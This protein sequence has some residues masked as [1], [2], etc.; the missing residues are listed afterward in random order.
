[1]KKNVL[2]FLLMASMVGMCALIATPIITDDG[3]TEKEVTLEQV[4]KAV[5]DTILK[6]AGDHKITE[7]EEVSKDG[8][9]IYYEAEWKVGR[10]EVEIMVDPNGKLL[11]KEVEEDDD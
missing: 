7:I 6:E 1:M 8:K 9:V 10:K 4:P 5:K 3:E 11:G 2:F